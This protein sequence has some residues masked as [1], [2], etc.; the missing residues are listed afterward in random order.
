[1]KAIRTMPHN[2]IVMARTAQA[3]TDKF[4]SIHWAR[5]VIL[6]FAYHAPRMRTAT[7]TNAGSRQRTAKI[8]HW[9]TGFNAKFMVRSR[10]RPPAPR[11]RHNP[12]GSRYLHGHGRYGIARV[13]RVHCQAV[14]LA[15]V[16]S[17]AQ[18]MPVDGQYKPNK[19]RIGDG[20][21][22][23]PAARFLLSAAFSHGLW[24]IVRADPARLAFLRLL[25]A[26]F[27]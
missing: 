10:D 11:S 17:F 27:R 23:G 6:S 4:A 24:P 25:P 2:H 19:R 8:G 12:L 14:A 15:G 1:M 13:V 20:S 18:R 5:A 3:I 9:L 22:P 21:P 26:V 16:D 7:V